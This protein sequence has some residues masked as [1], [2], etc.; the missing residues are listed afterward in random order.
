MKKYKKFWAVLLTLAMVLGM[1]MTT[2][3]ATPSNTDEKSVTVQNLESGVTVTAYQFIKANYNKENNGFTGY[4]WVVDGD[5]GVHAG[6]AVTI[7][8]GKTDEVVGLTSDFITELAKNSTKLATLEKEEVTELQGNEAQLD[9]APG[10]WLILVTGGTTTSKIYNP[11]VASVYYA[12]S[13]SDG[14]M[15]G[16]PVTGGNWTL[17]T[18]GAYAKVSDLALTK[19]VNDDTKEAVADGEKEAEMATF[20]VT[21][22]IPSYS[23]AYGE[24]LTFT[25]KDK[26][27]DG[28]KYATDAPVVKVGDDTLKDGTEYKYAP[29]ADKKSFEIIFAK[30]YLRG[31]AAA[32]TNRSVVITYGAYATA[33]ATVANPG[34][35]TVTLEY[36]TSQT[37]TTTTSPKSEKVYTFDITG[38]VNKVKEDKTSPLPGATFTLYRAYDATTKTLSD[39]VKNYTTED[40]GAIVFSGLGAVETVNGV[41]QAGTGTYYLKETAAPATYTIN[42][43][44]YKVEIKN[45]TRNS[46]TDDTIKSYDV[47]VT[48]LTDNTTTTTTITVGNATPGG[49]TTNI[50]N[51]KLT[52]LP[53]TGGIGTTIFTIGGCA[54][55]IAAA[56]L[57]F[58][59]RK[60]NDNK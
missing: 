27:N 60:K 9:L 16:K 40:D 24:D 28:L 15:E 19:T 13:G 46:E 42:D 20:T 48:N 1:S 59:S 18:T 36:S 38:A 47:V 21:T 12:N 44:V 55:M 57:F 34:V 11:M 43:T 58:A 49:T 52:A 45:I 2:M 17:E 3:A 31:L 33:A 22:T 35:N 14:T 23:E 7:K 53:S 29:A 32:G 30:E 26:L 54:I 39:E 41:A 4:E 8:E 5:A 25:I 6:D 37:T 50:V 10:T 56:F 51:T